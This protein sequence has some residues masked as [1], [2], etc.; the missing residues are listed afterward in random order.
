M[1]AGALAA[2]GDNGDH[3]QILLF[4]ASPDVIE[5]GQSTTLVFV[6][7]P[8]N[9]KVSITGMGDLTGKSQ[10]SVA[11]TDTTSYQLTATS[12]KAVTNQTVRVTVGATSA[13]AIKVQPA[14]KT[15]TAGAPVAVTLTVLGPDGNPAMGFRGTVHVSSTDANAVLPAD[16]TFMA[17]EAG[18]KQVMVTLKAAGL[19]TLTATDVTGKANASGSASLTVQPAAAHS[20]QLDPLPGSATAGQALTLTV[21]VLDVFGN[22]ATAYGGKLHLTSADSTDMLP[23]DGTFSAGVLAVSLTFIKTG[24]HAVQINDVALALPSASSSSV[25]V[26]PGAPKVVLG[27]P[28]N[29]NSGFP[30]NVD[31]VIRDLFENA[32]P[33]YAGTVSFATTD[34][35]TGA[36]TPASITF[37]GSEGGVSTTTVTFVTMGTQT[38]SATG[39]AAS[40]PQAL[41]SA[42]AQ[43][44]GLVYTAPT[45]GKVRLVANA[46]SNP[47]T[48][49][50]DLVASERLT[51]SSFFGGPGSF[52][53]GMNLPLDTT[54]VGAGTPLFTRGLALPAGT[55]VDAS[56]GVIGSDHVLYTGVSRK[57]TPNNANGTN[58]VSI[59]DTQVNAGDVFYSVK[60]KL[61][62]NGPPG[63]VFDG[64]QPTA[65]FRAAVRDQFG[66][67]FV[68]QVDFGVGKLEIR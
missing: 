29:A 14:T 30:V 26:G 40:G 33:N 23:S 50:L 12:G 18:V 42:V 62:Q 44:H 1:V 11:P 59:Q 7:E 21:K 37:S 31:V 39:T 53:A 66:D 41:G 46:A 27:L 51:V 38:L 47:Q 64:A 32:I 43:V 36:T 17:G 56:A 65:M 5:S 68:G 3:V 22:V 4:Q 24:N 61:T 34:K 2:C 58:P 57:R 6:V 60:L 49:Q 16:V 25:A 63:T 15:P 48:I 35:G 9:A 52:T 20:Y 45:T 13:A 19:S 54:R 8:A 10:V 55:G 28:L 67:D